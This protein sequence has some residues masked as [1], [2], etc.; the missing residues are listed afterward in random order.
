MSVPNFNTWQDYLHYQ[1]KKR[2]IINTLRVCI[3]LG[4]LLY[5]EL[6]TRY[7]IID[8]FFYSSPSRIWKC[9]VMLAESGTLASHL[10]VTIWETCVSFIIVIAVAFALAIVL[11][12]NDT[13]HKVAEPYLVILNSLPKSALAPL[14]IVWFGSSSLT[15]II[16][17]VSVAVFGATMTVYQA[18]SETEPDKI[19]LIYTLGGN[20][21]DVLRRIIIPGN[22]G[23]L[24]SVMKV[25][26]GLS[27]VGVI[28]G[29]FLGAKTGLGYLIIYGSQTFQLDFVIMSIVLLSILATTLYLL[30]DALQK[31]YQRRK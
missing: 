17:A 9:F 22:I 13:L 28:I 21:L 15:I 11:W 18:F 29:E 31:W 16:A 8:S 10:S 2:L 7:G 3:M 6:G 25:N 4:F 20:K 24:L 14:F 19:K 12:W 23:T 5:W 1:K 27:L 26:M 30:L